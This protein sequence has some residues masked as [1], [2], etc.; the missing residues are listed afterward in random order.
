M[1]NSFELSSLSCMTLEILAVMFWGMMKAFFW[2]SLK[3]AKSSGG[4]GWNSRG[5]SSPL[6]LVMLLEEAKPPSSLQYATQVFVSWP[7]FNAKY[8]LRLWIVG[9]FPTRS[10]FDSGCGAIRLGNVRNV[11]TFRFLQ[12]Y[13][14]QG[15][16]CRQH[17]QLPFFIDWK[18]DEETLQI[19]I[20]QEE[21]EQ[22]PRDVTAGYRIRCASWTL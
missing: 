12:R 14:E 15:L 8:I 3:Q 5:L 22:N 10:W 17:T 13:S 20:T 19:N 7:Y 18:G 16:I 1:I 9:H 2:Q 6:C 4:M 11:P 21:T